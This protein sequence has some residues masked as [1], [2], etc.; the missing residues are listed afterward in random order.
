MLPVETVLPALRAALE[1]AP[2]AVLVAPPGAGKT[3]VVPTALLGC[4]WVAGGRILVL[5]PRRL[6]AR[7][8][9]Q[10]M[11]ELLGE[12]VGRT[13]G[14][15]VRL[16]AKVSAATRIEVVTEGVFTRRLL[17][18]PD[19]PGVAAVIFDEFHERALD[20][21]LGLALALDAQDGLRPD[22]RLLVM[23]ATLD[24]ARVS[25]LLGDA[26]VIVSEGRMHPIRDVYLGRSPESPL[27]VA[28]ADAARRAAAQEEGGILC[29]L[30]GVADIH[31][32]QGRLDE[33][34]RDPCVDVSVLHGG[35][36]L[37]AQAA[38]LARSPP[39]RRK[40]VLAT[41]IAETSLTIPDIR[42]VVDSGMA[43]RPAFDADAGVA[44]LVTVQASRAAVTQRRGRAGR[45]APGVC[46]RLWREA[47]TP[48]FP[49][50]DRP[51]MFDAD[52]SGL[53]LTLAA[54]GV[55]TPAA[56]RLPDQPPAASWS[57]ATALLKRLGALDADGGL[58]DLGRAMDGFGLPPRLSAMILK[59]REHGLGRIAARAAAVLTERGAGGDDL[60]I[61]VRIARFA[62]ERG[63]RVQA[64]SRLVDSWAGDPA[65]GGDEA[66]L[67]RVL[68]PVF[69]D[70]IARARDR[71]GAFT[72]ASGRGVEA[73]PEHRLAGS[74]WLIVADLMGAASGARVL[75][76]VGVED[77]AAETLF[78]EAIETR[79]TVA[80][81]P[82]ESVVRAEEVRSLGA[83]T[84]SRR[85]LPRPTPQEAA[86][87]VLEQVRSTRLSGLSMD[88]PVRS[89][90][91]RAGFLRGQSPDDWPDLSDAVLLARL[92]EWLAP[93]V[94]AAGGAPDP[95]PGALADA[96]AGLFDWSARQALDREAPARFTSPAGVSHP[97]DYA[98]PA[99]PSVDLRVQEL[100]GLDRHPTV[101]RGVHLVLR[102][103]S[104]AHRPVAVTRDLP[105]FWRGAWADVRKDMKARYPKHP[106]PEDPIQAAP[107]TRAKPRP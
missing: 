84:L 45:T 66:D 3:T 47:E 25:A 51:E 41:S 77:D 95:G 90:R 104:P 27:G 69:G 79:R 18:E 19:L 53:A 83:L 40:L 4:E 88:G 58:S 59:A 93:A 63:P 49:A 28:V 72:I 70:R 74:P 23:S 6:A 52:L 20:A 76:A 29:F 35:L 94:I 36:D 89:L 65:Q 73:P 34:L 97:I 5:A 30:P 96:I 38:V 17:G 60:D 31:R 98:D 67:P 56:L 12:P 50:E 91:D 39:G 43:R 85:P 92:E 61:G 103:T 99:G 78:A 10:R 21:D 75:A 55:R 14:Y 106:W 80:W 62:Q 33:T 57:A 107:T 48:A 42:V 32:A 15:R 82:G 9:A 64:L 100:F 2:N 71:R 24:A 86:A 7:A 26:P 68:A 8:A 81:R 44:R 22:L 16:D 11:A 1:R 46:Y 37:G 87:A 54:W 105:G 101:G 13:V 102:L